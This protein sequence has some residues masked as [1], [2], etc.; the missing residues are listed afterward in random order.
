MGR[1]RGE[2]FLLSFSRTHPLNGN[3][4]EEVRD[5]DDQE[6]GKDIEANDKNTTDLLMRVLK[7]KEPGVGECCRKND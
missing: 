3:V 5:E 7:H 6:S 4:Y 1:T 2:S